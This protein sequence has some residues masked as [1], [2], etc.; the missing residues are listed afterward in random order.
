MPTKNLKPIKVYLT[1]EQIAI[2]NDQPG[3]QGRSHKMVELL[4]EA[5]TTRGG[6]WPKRTP[7]GKYPRVIIDDTSSDSKNTP[8]DQ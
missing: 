2:I 4:G 8:L 3:I 6:T 5:I 7:R 1:P